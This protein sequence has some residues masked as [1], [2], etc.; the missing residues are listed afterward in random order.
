[1]C[2][3]ARAV[4]YDFAM[5][6]N[7]IV[8]AVLVIALSVTAFG[9]S[10]FDTYPARTVAELI[11]MHS[12]EA[13]HGADFVI[14]ADPF[15]SKS[16]VVFSGEHRPIDK[17][18]KDFIGLWLETRGLEKERA[19]MLL[20]E[21]R[22]TEKGV[23]YWLPVVKPL[24]PFIEQELKQ[25]DKIEIY[26]FFQGGYGPKETEAKNWVFVVEEFRKVVESPK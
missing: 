19:D 9:Q 17:K 1:M 20:E 23:D 14:S 3:V 8:A 25:G 7:S 15:P 22:F 2:P 10:D 16:V 12:G 26:F 21:Y 24:A 13:S 11:T 5:R 4:R 18:K 6:H